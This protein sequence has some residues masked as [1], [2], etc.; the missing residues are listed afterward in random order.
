MKINKMNHWGLKFLK[1]MHKRK[2]GAK[3][4]KKIEKAKYSFRNWGFIVCCSICQKL[5][6]TKKFLRWNQ[7]FPFFIDGGWGWGAYF[8]K[9]KNQEN[10]SNIDIRNS[11]GSSLN[12]K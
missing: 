2:E 12:S 6:K 4:K 5:A 7:Y 9:K 11:D 1:W 3:K 10:P 8:G